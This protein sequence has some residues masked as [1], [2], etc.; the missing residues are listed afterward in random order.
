MTGQ[1]EREREREHRRQQMVGARAR[2]IKEKTKDFA[3]FKLDLASV[4][5][6]RPL[7]VES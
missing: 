7:T 5:I 3:V 2:E 1:T 6:W 4:W